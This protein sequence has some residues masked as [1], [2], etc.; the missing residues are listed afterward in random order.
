MKFVPFVLLSAFASL[1]MVIGPSCAN[2]V[3]PAGGPRDSLPPRLVRSSPSNG[4]T[5]FRGKT[6]EMVFDEYLDIA[7]PQKNFLF[8]PTFNINPDVVVKSRTIII[9][10]KD[11]LEANTTYTFNFG[12]AIRDINESN[13]LHNFTYRM[14]TGPVLDSLTLEGKVLLAETGTVDSTLSVFL[15]KNLNDSAVVKERP[16]Y[17][18]K[19]NGNGTFRFENLS[20]GTYKIYALN[21]ATGGHRYIAKTQ[22]FAFADSPVVV[23]PGVPRV[24]LYAYKAPV[25]RVVVSKPQPPAPNDRRMRYTTNLSGGQQDL[26]KNL[27]LQFERPLRL[28][29]SNKVK[30]LMDS[31]YRETGHSLLLDSTRRRITIKTKW[32]EGAAYHLVLNKD[33][34]EDSSGRKLL[35]AD[36]IEFAAKKV[37]DYGNLTIRIRNADLGNNPVLQFIQGGQVLFS[38]P[39]PTGSYSNNLFSPGDYELRVLYDTNKNGTWDAGEF[40]DVKRQPEL[41]KPVER[42]ITVKPNWDN[43]FEIAL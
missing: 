36:T 7:E 13:I 35:K 11:S 10:L 4:S 37:S 41:V 3:P 34:A 21:D 8:T 38:A 43:E 20:P 14:S 28:F 26:L 5:N 9:R 39:I 17:I 25:A 24:T 31:T 12:D 22:L 32:Q 19:L 16:R 2:I 29:D 30:L 6:I 15:Y 23:Q 42:K 27:E 33:F 18:T 1:V 40:F